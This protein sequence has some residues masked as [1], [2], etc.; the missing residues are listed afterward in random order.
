[1]EG[2]DTDR[3]DP[4][5]YYVPM[6]QR[7]PRFV[8][9]AVQVAG[10]SPL[11]ITQG[12]REVVRSLNPNQPIYNVSAMDD[13]VRQAGWFFAVFGTLFIVFGA[14]AL[15]MA[16]VGLYGVL[17]FS[18]SRRI[19]E[20]GIRMALGAGPKQVVRLVVG[21]GARQLALGL[22]MGLLLA[23]GVTRVIGFLM[24]EVTPQDPPV[25]TGVTLLIATVGLLASFI[26][27]RQATLAQ[28]SAALRA[29]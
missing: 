1:M 2:I 29:E 16:T 14:A 21:Q 9:M 3:P 8:S 4:W 25:F 28:P 17:S 5:G 24:F 12:V 27:A 18:V 11:A 13:V 10:G 22:G 26:P 23:F 19:R 20:M 6:A 15:F 7:D